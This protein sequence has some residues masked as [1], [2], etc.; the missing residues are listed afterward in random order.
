MKAIGCAASPW[1][2]CIPIIRWAMKIN[3]TK[4]LFLQL[5]WA[6]NQLS[7]GYYGWRAGTLTTLTFTDG[8]TLRI[9]PR[10]NAGTVALQYLFAQLHSQSQWAQ[11]VSSDQG[12]SALYTTM[13]GDPWSH[14]DSANPIFPPGLT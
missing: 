5:E 11:I 14:G 10:L 1:M 2:P 12:F 3:L 4:G 9:D 7:I 6:I 13:F 8:S